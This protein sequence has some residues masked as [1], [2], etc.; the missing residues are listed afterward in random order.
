[1]YVAREFILPLFHVSNV[2]KECIHANVQAS[3]VYNSSPLALMQNSL[4]SS[5]LKHLIHDYGWS[6][7]C[8]IQLGHCPEPIFARTE[9]VRQFC[10]FLLCSC[11]QQGRLQRSRKLSIKELYEALVILVVKSSRV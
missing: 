5:G 2:L 10:L 6:L 11:Y 3:F 7:P 1:M 8:S 4:E 9:L